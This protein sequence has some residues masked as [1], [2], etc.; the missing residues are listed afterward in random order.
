MIDDFPVTRTVVE[1]TVRLV[2]TARLRPSVLAKL[3]PAEEMDLLAEIEGVTSERLIRQQR[4]ATNMEPMEFVAG[5]PMATFI[6]AAFAYPRPVG[7]NRF[8]GPERGAWYAATETETSIAEVAYHLTRELE[9]TGVFEATVDYA[10]MHAS[11]IGEFLDLREVPAPLPDCLSPNVEVAYP[12]G[13]AIAEAARARGL[14]GILYPSAR[15]TGGV[16]LVALT[17]HAVQDVR[18]G[19][20]I[21]LQW[22]GK[23]EPEIIDD[24]KG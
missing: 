21:R 22:T 17:P 10:E 8:N 6:N 16:C 2:A 1:R 11:F 14:S 24:F 7:L 23:R 18:Q 4:G 3:V 5:I 20:V 12:H 19:Q 15:R 13:N 9:N